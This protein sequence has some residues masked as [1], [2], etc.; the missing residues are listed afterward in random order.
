MTSGKN[1]NYHYLAQQY[2]DS[3]KILEKDLL[4]NN[5]SRLLEENKHGVSLLPFFLLNTL[6]FSLYSDFHF[7]RFSRLLL[8]PERIVPGIKDLKYSENSITKVLRRIKPFRKI[9]NEDLFTELLGFVFSKKYKKQYGQFY[10]P[11]EVVEY[12][13]EKIPVIPGMKIMDPAC[14]TGCF[15]IPV[16]RKLMSLY[17]DKTS[18]TDITAEKILKANIFGFELNPVAVHC[19]TL[20]LMHKGNLIDPVTTN[21]VCKDALVKEANEK[22]YDIVIGNP[23]YISYG[24]RGTDKIDKDRY[25]Y[26]KENYRHSAQYKISQYPL[27]IERGLELLKEGGYLGYI[28]PDSFL[29]G[30]YYSRIRGHMLNTANIIEISLLEGKIWRKGVVGKSVIIILQ[31]EKTEKKRKNNR[32]Q[33]NTFSNIKKRKGKTYSYSQNYFNTIPLQRFRLFF[34]KESKEFVDKMENAQYRLGDIVSIASGLIGKKGK[35]SIISQEKINK[36][37]LPGIISSSQATRYSVKYEGDFINFNR[38]DLKSGFLKALYFVPKLFIRQTADR[39]IAAYE[40]S[41]LLC[42]NNLHV[43]NV[44]DTRFN[45]FFLLGLLNSSVIDKYYRIIS[46]ERKRVLPQT[47]IEMLEEIPVAEVSESDQAKIEELVKNRIG[48][49][50]GSYQVRIKNIEK[51]IDKQILKMYGVKV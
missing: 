17:R 26:Y 25:S 18:N 36:D 49:N 20:N 42:L 12:I 48:M 29:T 44:T 45:I 14:G 30:K 24:L 8:I 51:K 41:G 27:F 6:I 15:I 34:D 39:I 37:W 31:K 3:I 46:L 10:T 16:F 7:N 5:P 28:I 38:G 50:A 32:V 35:A 4:E 19:A 47:D 1:I 22:K 33:V 43:L 13:V 40:D 11:P 23:P 2:H 21:I 9:R